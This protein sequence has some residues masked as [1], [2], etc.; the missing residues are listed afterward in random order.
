M[1]KKGILL[2]LLFGVFLT[3]FTGK[4]QASQ[5]DSS[6]KTLNIYAMYLN[7]DEKSDSVLLESKGE[8]LLMD[9]GRPSCAEAIIKQLKALNVQNVSIYFSHMHADHYGGGT[10]YL[11]GIRMI[12]D[13][14]FFIDKLYMPSDE[15][16]PESASYPTKFDKF[17]TFM[18]ANGGEVIR[19]NV[20]SQFFVGDAEIDIIG[21]L[22][23]MDIH[24]SDTVTYVSYE[25]NR[26]L[27]A[28]VICGNRRFFTAGD[29]MGVEAKSLVDAYGSSLKADIMKLNHHGT[30]NG[31]TASLLSMIAPSYSFA[32][33]CGI[34]KIDETTGCWTT[35]PAFRNARKYGICYMTG[36]NKKTLIYH[37]E[38]DTI[39]MYYSSVQPE[40]L[41][42]GWN[43]ISGG[44]GQYITAERFF[45]DGEGQP[46]Q[47]IQTLNGVKMYFSNGIMEFGS[48]KNT[49]ELSLWKS[50]EE[51]KRYF[52][53]LNGNQFSIMLTGFLTIDGIRYYFD[54]NGICLQ[55][56]DGTELKSIEGN[57]YAV[58]KT[59]E[60]VC[61]KCI[62]VN[63]QKYY[64]N[65]N[66]I[67]QKAVMMKL[68]SHYYYFDQNGKM[69]RGDTEPKK[70]TIGTA[71]YAFDSA[72]RRIESR[73]VTIG[74]N[75]YYFNSKGKMVKD[76][77][78]VINEKK[79]YFNKKGRLLVADSVPALKKIR[80]ATYAVKE[81]GE[82]AVNQKLWIG[83]Y[84]YCFGKK[85]QLVK[86]KRIT[87]DGLTYCTDKKGHVI[88]NKM[89]K[90]GSGLYYFGEDGIMYTKCRII[91]KQYVYSCGKDG[92]MKKVK[93][94]KIEPPAEEQAG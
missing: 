26:S 18:E 40:N 30:G 35:F 9:I 3:A 17:I 32:S 91:W 27:A 21:P 28:M 6:G 29:C 2:L 54:G 19:L 31:N 61:G 11:E 71:T 53:F 88:K 49:G 1:Q 37:I 12:R 77:F 69:V 89:V 84:H 70:K 85:G 20:G 8:Y 59:G 56:R 82:L 83:K 72:G 16:A 58:K 62:S 55:G 33:S 92:K 13:A 15:V 52:T 34:D 51:G 75:Q 67:M 42:V 78:V 24:P 60:I 94:V 41:L 4:V 7:S 10:T 36:R 44:D 87:I 63:H 45:L 79:Y 93:K 74:D 80:N 57:T 23:N 50:Y 68:D 14:G 38:N 47:G 64:F 73:K 5:N 90:I 43:E 46:L 66:G 39:K 65:Q 81:N 86:S 25:N 48:F 22:D 76:K